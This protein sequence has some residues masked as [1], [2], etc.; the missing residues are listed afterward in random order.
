MTNYIRNFF[1]IR[2]LLY[3]TMIYIISLK[4]LLFRFS[5]FSGLDLSIEVIF[6]FLLCIYDKRFNIFLLSIMFLICDIIQ[7]NPLGLSVLAVLPSYI[8]LKIYS[9]VI[10]NKGFNELFL[11]YILACFSYLHIKYLFMIILYGIYFNYSKMLLSSVG[12][13]SLVPLSHLIFYSWLVSINDF[14][15]EY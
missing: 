7:A 11:H 15:Q 5:L 2:A 12:T 10:S 13:I 8:Y 14:N 9:S 6:L 4:G 1:N 3:I